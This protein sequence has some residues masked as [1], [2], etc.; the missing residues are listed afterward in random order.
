MLAR[1]ESETKKSSSG[2]E[3]LRAVW[4]AKR[5]DLGL[6]Q[7]IAADEL[8]FKSQGSVADYLNGRMPLGLNAA[9]GFARLLKVQLAEIW[10]GDPVEDLIDWGPDQIKKIIES[11][12]SPNQQLEL[13][14][15]MAELLQ[16]R[17]QD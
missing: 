13:M 15:Y 9:I 12:L 11:R 14:A 1:V 8:G 16:Q 3:K 17:E 7:A 6:T 4:D 2:H 5:K 10:E